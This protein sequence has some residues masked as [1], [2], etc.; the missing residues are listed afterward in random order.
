MKRPVLFLCIL[1]TSIS[2]LALTP[3]NSAESDRTFVIGVLNDFQ[4]HY[5][6][7]ASGKPGGFAIE[8]F[9]EIAL[10][11]G[12]Q[13]RYRE[14][15]NWDEMLTSLR[16]GEIDIIPNLGITTERKKDF[17]F[18]RPIEQFSLGLFVRT[19]SKELRNIASL[20]GKTVAVVEQNAGVKFITDYPDI[21]KRIFK[22]AE[23]ALFA[24]LAGDVDGLVYPVPIA[25][26]LIQRHQI[27]G[28]ITQ[29]GNSLLEINRALAVRHDNNDLLS[30]LDKAIGKVMDKPVFQKISQRWLEGEDTANIDWKNINNSNLG[31][32]III[33]VLGLLA[34]GL[35]KYRNSSF[36]QKILPGNKPQS[37]F[38]IA[39]A[40]GVLIV[41]TL[42]LFETESQETQAPTKISVIHLSNVD[43]STYAG[44]LV[45]MKDLGYHQ[46]VNIEYIYKGP[47]NRIDRL[48]SL[49]QSHLEHKPDIILVSSTPGTLAVKR[50]T[51]EMNI[52]V[53]FAPVNDPVDA[54][55]VNNAQHPGGY[56]TGVR[57]PTGDD[58]RLQWLRNI[59][60]HAK[61]V[62]VPYTKGDKSA[63]ATLRIIKQVAEQLGLELIIKQIS[64]ESIIDDDSPAVPEEIDAIFLPRDSTIEAR[65][66][67]FIALSEKRRLPLSVPSAKQ[68]YAG[69]LFSYG[70][71]HFEI[72]RQSAQIVDQ[73]IR[74]AS[75]GD[76]PV[77]SA[78]NHMLIN[79]KAAKRIG[80][81]IPPKVLNQADMLIRE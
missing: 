11:A 5:K 75:P 54:G 53:V 19:T 61:K 15:N 57:L 78:E 80:I 16:I 70:F 72:G 36:F 25:N 68:V 37:A 51:E 42:Y 30:R 44:F 4:P 29:A 13:Y 52:P 6:K 71:V 1:L 24:L 79:M 62:F 40:L 31:R 45:E 56:I 39:A 58:L 77:L 81:T 26:K 20:S 43:A 76:L 34:I 21:N 46:G 74:G 38:L 67:E 64:S 48:D 27:A 50:I 49:I 69:A 10:E 33:T 59:A 47:A 28:M 35:L 3:L 23:E 8:L 22:H 17:N 63:S 73:V 41:L 18:S 55:I 2:L 32:N 60:P 66:G 65:I 9:E 12:I 7:Q 14:L